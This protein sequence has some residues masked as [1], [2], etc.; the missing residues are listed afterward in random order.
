VTF[1]THVRV[2]EVGPRDGLQNE[3]TPIPTATKIAFVQALARAGLSDVE[4]SSFV[5][6]DLVPQLADAAE[7]FAGLEKTAS[8]RYWA[9]VPNGRGL[10]AARDAGVRSVAVFTAASE[11]FN[12]ANIGAGVDEALEL[13]DPVIREAKGAGLR[14]RG[15]VST[16]FGCPYDGAVS[17]HAGARVARALLDSGCDEISL[18]DTI[19]VAVP[20]DIAR[21]LDACDVA[22]VDRA[23]LALHL[24]DTRGAA[25]ANV[26]AALSAG[27]ATFDSSA[28]GLGGCPFAP[29]ATGNLA[30]EDLLYLLHGLG[31]ETG[32]SFDGVAEASGIAAQ[33]LGRTLP[34]RARAAWAASKR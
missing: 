12:R 17:P 18:G 6:P 7:V 13:L 1:P 23:R 26:Y 21:V 25:L 9:L 32:V 14:V 34:S 33:A 8:P 22:G 19:G 29:G 16:V 31:I 5:R 3:A 11:G 30:T 10:A 2:V 15:Y 24:H 27:I 20:S 28:G 4:V